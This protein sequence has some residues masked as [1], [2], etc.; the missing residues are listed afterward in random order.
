MRKQLLAIGSISALALGG[1]GL[2]ACDTQPSVDPDQ[3]PEVHVTDHKAPTKSPEQKFNPAKKKPTHDP[4]KYGWW[5]DANKDVTLQGIATDSD[6]GSKYVVYRITNHSDTMLDYD[7]TF[8]EY[9]AQGV[10]IGEEY[11]MNDSVAPGETVQ[12]SSDDTMLDD[13][14]VTVKVIHVGRMSTNGSD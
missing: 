2:T 4:H 13:G 7:I 9:D 11:G 14:T 10:R 3:R 5:Y 12:S 1:L 6:L 8:G